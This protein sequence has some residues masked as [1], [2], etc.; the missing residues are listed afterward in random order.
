MTSLT[1]SLVVIT[2]ISIGVT[3]KT[4]G[5]WGYRQRR[6]EESNG[7]ESK[8]RDGNCKGTVLMHFLGP[9]EQCCQG[10]ILI[11]TTFLTPLV[12]RRLWA[13]MVAEGAT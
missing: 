12:V 3:P 13:R 8:E 6:S 4:V 11:S 10:P 9:T 2:L 1:F 7:Q 5:I